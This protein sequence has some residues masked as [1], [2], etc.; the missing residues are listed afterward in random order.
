MNVSAQTVNNMRNGISMRDMLVAKAVQNGYNPF[1]KSTD[2]EARNVTDEM[3][4]MTRNI[5]V[6]DTKAVSA[7]KR[8]AVIR[9]VNSAPVKKETSHR[10]EVILLENFELVTRKSASLS[11]GMIVSV[12]VSAMVLAMVVFS[13]SFINEEA[14]RN[15]ELNNAIEILKEED[16]NLTLALEEKNNIE[17]I[18]DIAVNQL[19]M[20]SATPASYQ[21]LSL[22]EGDTVKVYGVEKED[23]SVTVNLLNTF[24][25]KISGF[26]EYLD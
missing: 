2:A 7:L 16:K 23:T 11:L 9:E 14:R 12:I 15:T 4:A 3:R 20:I 18:E 21:Y 17:V 1:C 22:S 19:G 13:G 26:L 5:S 10:R 8:K 25:E 6:P 24:G